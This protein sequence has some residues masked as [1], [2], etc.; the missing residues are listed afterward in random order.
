VL[1]SISPM[2]LRE[3]NLGFVFRII[4]NNG[5]ISRTD[6]VQHTGLAPS[7]VSVITA[8]LH[9][10]R[11]IRTIGT[12]A[13]SGGRRPILLQVNPEGGYFICV[14]LVGTSLAIGLLDLSFKVQREWDQEMRDTGEDLYQ[15]VVAAIR[16]V[17]RHCTVLG[18]SI[19]G[20]G[21]AAPGLLDA[22]SGVIVEADN[23]GWVEF[24]LGERLEAE[25]GFKVVIEHDVN[26]AAFGEYLYGKSEGVRN[27]MYV[28]I[29]LGIG[30]GLI[31]DGQLFT[32][33]NGLAGELG[34]ITVD[35]EG[36]RCLCGK[37]GCLETIASG[38]AM[39]L[40]YRKQL[41]YM[42]NEAQGEFLEIDA[43]SL[44]HHAEDGQEVAES[45]I[46][47]A[48]EAIGVALGNQVNILNVDTIILGGALVA[49]SP[50]MFHAILRGVDHAL[51]PRLKDHLETR[52]S[53]LGVHAGYIGIAFLC[54]TKLF[55]AA[56]VV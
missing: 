26:A 39:V 37:R 22:G 52:P 3:L 49:R 27:M 34:H 15:S 1:A 29:G 6:I 42:G 56:N 45:L 44:V 9:E 8:D 14:D 32:G 28:S 47:R 31:L 5:P 40:E 33:T 12:A 30:C 17:V 11:L 2:G 48:G 38:R 54:F 43:R 36:Q 13:S 55:A 46:N 21:V 51:L 41:Q 18:L 10:K 35:T 24:P 7:T 16:D 20:L 4:Q 23:L 19:L 25:F 53:S 50:K